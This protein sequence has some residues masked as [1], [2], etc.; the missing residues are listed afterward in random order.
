MYVYSA[1]MLQKGADVK[2][3]DLHELD[4]MYGATKQAKSYFLLLQVNAQEL[5]TLCGTQLVLIE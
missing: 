1:C 3:V 5:L 2:F 4:S